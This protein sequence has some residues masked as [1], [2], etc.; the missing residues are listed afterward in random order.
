MF[1]RFYGGEVAVLIRLNGQEFT[2]ESVPGILRSRLRTGAQRTFGPDNFD[3]VADRH[4]SP[5]EQSSITS[6][7]TA[8]MRS[9][10]DDAM[11][12]MDDGSEEG[13]ASPALSTS[14]FPS[15]SSYTTVQTPELPF[16]LEEIAPISDEWPTKGNSEVSDPIVYPSSLISHP[17]PK[18]MHELVAEVALRTGTTIAGRP[19]IVY[20]RPISIRT[21]TALITMANKC[22]AG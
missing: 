7:S 5:A 21:K 10:W 3:T 8:S 2:Y 22:F 16:P 11:N 18:S 6:E 9:P 15:T 4:Q 12:T 20:P 13:S 17:E 19:S 14:S 1:Y